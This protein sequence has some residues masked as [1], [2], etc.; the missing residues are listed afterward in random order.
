[1]KDI[2]ARYEPEN[3]FS[4]D[5][6]D[7]SWQMLPVKSLGFIGEQQRVKKQSKTSITVLVGAN[8]SSSEKMPLFA[9]EKA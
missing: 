9:I 7:L 6:T 5:E 3:V 2:L 4:C 1:M 8:M